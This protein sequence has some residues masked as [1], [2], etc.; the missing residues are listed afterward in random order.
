M[1]KTNN[2]TSA[3]SIV[4]LI[5]AAFSLSACHSI[6][7]ESCVGGDWESIGFKDGSKGKKITKADKYN[8]RCAKFDAV[9]DLDSYQTGY[10]AGLPRYCTF[11]NGYER[12]IDGSS[13]NKV[14][15]GDLAQD[16]A[17]GYEQGRVIYQIYQEHDSMLAQYENYDSALFSVR[18]K[19]REDDITDKERERLN[20]K[21]RRLKQE[22]Y[23][24]QREI[25]TFERRYDLPISSLR[26]NSF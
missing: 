6:S 11:E 24:L 25:R 18:R 8:K 12:G 1:I 14:C 23:V 19:L 17:P 5:A 2:I 16:Y 4:F 15:A 10:E 22:M 20:R 26:R 7:E 9:V 21:A 3:L 13:Y